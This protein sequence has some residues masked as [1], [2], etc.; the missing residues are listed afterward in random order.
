MSGCCMYRKQVQL[1]QVLHL[2][3]RDVWDTGAVF[4][5]VACVGQSFTGA[6]VSCVGQSFHW[7]R[8]FIYGTE[9]QFL[10]QLLVRD[11]VFIG[12]AVACVGQC[13]SIFSYCMCG[14]GKDFQCV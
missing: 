5:S 2:S 12:A 9:V 8:C 14:S 1:E 13:C 10:Q 3:N 4:A 6:Y 7:C 11:R